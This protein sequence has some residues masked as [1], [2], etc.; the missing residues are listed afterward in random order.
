MP[1]RSGRI[2]TGLSGGTSGSKL[3]S[4]GTSN[5]YLYKCHLKKGK[6]KRDQAITVELRMLFNAERANEEH[7]FLRYYVRT[8]IKTPSATVYGALTTEFYAV[9]AAS[10]LVQNIVP[11]IVGTIIGILLLLVI[12]AMLWK[13]GAFSKMRI[14]QKRMDE[15]LVNEQ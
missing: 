4:C 14:F 1:I 3:V 9:G 15:A 12:L 7:N 13:S 2:Y 8:L 10:A 5:C 6:L 11:F